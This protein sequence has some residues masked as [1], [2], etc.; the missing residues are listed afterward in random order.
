MLVSGIYRIDIGPHF[1]YGSSR[2]IS[3]RISSHKNGLSTGRHKNL[4]MLRAFKV[5]ESFSW[6]IILKCQESELLVRE[7]AYL[8]RYY[9][10]RECLNLVSNAE[11]PMSCPDARKRL[12]ERNSN[13]FWSEE[14]KEKIAAA[15]RGSKHTEKQKLIWSKNR[16]R[17]LNANS[18]LSK[19]AVSEIIQLRASGELISVLSKKFKVHYTTIQ[20]CLKVNGVKTTRPKK[21][22]GVQR[23]AILEA[24]RRN[25]NWNKREGRPGEDHSNAILTNKSVKWIRENSGKLSQADMAEKLGVSESTVGAVVQGRTWTHLPRA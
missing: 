5:Y 18:R 2:N 24:R 13:M 16:M 14:M 20:R 25:P 4:R 8:D 7:Q 19:K 22:T 12:G 6:K 11:S 10:L 3:R 17:H 15:H 21:W 1:Y 9:G 23:K